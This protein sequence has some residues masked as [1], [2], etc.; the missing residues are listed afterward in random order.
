MTFRRAGWLAVICGAA[1]CLAA[2]ARQSALGA[3]G[4][5]DPMPFPPLPEAISSFGAT[6]EGGYLY[7]F[8]GHAGRIPGSSL[9][10]LSP[11]FVRISLADPAAGWETLPMHEA[12]QSPGLVAHGGKLFR[13][14]GL[15]FRNKQGEETR[16]HSL[17]IF[18]EYDPQTRA[19]T[20]RAKLP[21]PRSSLDAA[22]VDGRL[23]VVGGWNL[24]E[25]S[26]QD[27]PWHDE[28]LAIDLADAKAAWQPIAKPPFQTRALA[29]AGYRHKLYVLGGMTSEN[30]VTRD[31]HIYDPATDAWSVGPELAG[32]EQLSGFAI[33]A[34]VVDDRLY[35]SGSEGVVYRL[36]DDGAKWES[37]ERLLFPRSFHR[38]VGGAGRVYAVAGVARG[39]GYLANVEAIDVARPTSGPKV[40][41]FAIEFGG[42]T[43]QGQALWVQG[44]SLY[45]FGGNKSRAP[46]D[47]SMEMFSDEAYRFDVA[48]RSV[49]KLPNLPSPVQG[50]AAHLSG[51]RIDQSIY[52]L[53][54]LGFQDNA[55]QSLD[56][57]H[58]Y[59]LRSKAWV[60]ETGRLPGSRAMFGLAPHGDN[61]WI[62]GGSQVRTAD[63]GHARTAWLWQPASG[64]PA[65]VREEAAIPTPRRSFGGAVLGERYYAVGGLGEKTGLVETAEAFD[66]ATEKWGKIASP[67]VPRVFP[68]LAQSGGKLYVCGGFTQVDGHFQPAKTIEMYDPATDAWRTVFTDLALDPSAATMIE[69]QDRLLFFG[70]DRERD[71]VARFALVDPNPTTAGFGAP[72]VQI[73][74]RSALTADLLARLLRLDKDKDGKLTPDEVGARFLPIIKRAD[75]NQDGAASREELEAALTAETAAARQPRG[76]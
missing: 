41:Q 10:A 9:H 34:F 39:G 50:G 53:G 18:A 52:V 15:S 70:V 54:G 32:G 29:A 44:S 16:F 35:Y 74:E 22:A 57:I 66:F 55:F 1:L 12:S 62:F 7:I 59:R 46:H 58:Q 51:Q 26:A 6:A 47:F 8:G 33:S 4:A 76:D 19:W 21:Q 17:D 27:A 42:E 67:T 61:V 72:P 48:A 3:E 43:K 23:Y 71:G 14:G 60:E 31:V 13:V 68:S 40:V 2:G 64:E 38:L 25:G 45:A 36:S 49:E 5:P 24:Q 65:Q 56:T 11:H 75:R 20:E 73:E 30:R 28:A 69:F 37:V 63:S